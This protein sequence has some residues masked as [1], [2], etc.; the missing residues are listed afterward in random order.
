MTVA[1]CCARRT[2]MERGALLEWSWLLGDS[3][4]LMQGRGLRQLT[5]DPEK[6]EG[7][8]QEEKSTD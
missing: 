4:Q 5:E 3:C 1:G 2:R 8:T 7:G 6:E